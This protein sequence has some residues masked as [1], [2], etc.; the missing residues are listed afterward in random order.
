M[1]LK[2]N[3]IIKIFLL[4]LILRLIPVL[5]AYDLAIG[6]DDTFQYDMLARSIEAGKGYRW[7]AQD[8]LD[9]IQQY[10]PM[11]I[12]EGEYDP[13]GVLTSFRPPGYP[14]FLALI[15]PVLPCL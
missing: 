12:V 2:K 5:I 3:T 8:D 15:F 7:Y 6:L 11:D 10:F 9:L 4:A 13:Q 14:A 1:N